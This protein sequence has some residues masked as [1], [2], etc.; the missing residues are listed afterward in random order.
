[1]AEVRGAGGLGAIQPHLHHLWTLVRFGLVGAL[2]TGVGL[3]IIATLDLG[4]HVDP[5]LANAAG[6][7]VGIAIGFSLN[8]GF[9]FKSD[10]H[11]GRTG[12]KYLVAVAIGFAVNQGVLFVASHLYGEMA[13]ARLAAQLTAM[14]VYTVLVFGL[15]RM[16]VFK[17]G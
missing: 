6:Y 15:C 3:A 14:A 7:A 12:A 4:F 13:L 5:H 16:W 1:M 2:N 9:V 10:G 8:R 17:G 11:I